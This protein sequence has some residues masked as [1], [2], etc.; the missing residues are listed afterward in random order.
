MKKEFEFFENTI[1]AINNALSFYED[2]Y[3]VNYY[4]NNNGDVD[5]QEYVMNNADLFKIAMETI[6]K[7]MVNNAGIYDGMM[8]QYDT[9]RSN[10]K[11]WI[12]CTLSINMF[13][14]FS[15]ELFYEQL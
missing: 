11:I 1:K 12:G 14:D 3:K 8:L 10:G 2:S 7:R 6:N 9:G 5:M 15:I 4:Y 13:K